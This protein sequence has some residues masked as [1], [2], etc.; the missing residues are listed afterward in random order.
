M[1]P[2]LKGEILRE[3][4]YDSQ[5]VWGLDGCYVW[6]FR[7]RYSLNSSTALKNAVVW[8]V[9]CRFTRLVFIIWLKISIDLHLIVVGK[10][11]ETEDKHKFGLSF[12]TICN[13]CKMSIIFNDCASH[14]ALLS[15]KYGIACLNIGNC[16][17]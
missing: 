1:V 15:I 13:R 8:Q 5:R 9:W 11:S 17:I 16:C 3:S 10:G 7:I 12:W 2:F 6:Y 4:Y 14:M